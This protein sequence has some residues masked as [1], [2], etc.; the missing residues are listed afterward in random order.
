LSEERIVSGQP[1]FDRQERIAWWDQERLFNARV[2]VVGAGAL[3]NEVL[4]NLALLG[5]GHVLVIDFD[6]IED[7]NLSRTVLFR[8]SDA[9]DGASKALVAAERTLALNPNPNAVIK[10]MHGNVVWELGSGVYRHMD[11]V[12]G[13]L[14]NLEARLAV[15]LGCWRAGKTWIDGG[16]W[17]LSGSVTVYDSSAEKAC[18]ECGMTPEHYRQ[19]KVRYSCTNETV[20]TNIRQGR[21]PTTQTTSAVVAAIQS[22]EAIK[23]LHGLPSFPGRQL[24]F[25]GAPH[26][27]TNSDYEPVRMTELTLNP[28]CLCHG[29][30]R[31]EQ[32]V[33]LSKARARETTPRQL[34]E[35]VE[36]KPGVGDLTLDLGRTFVMEAICSRCERHIELN[37]PLYRVRDVDAV[38]PTCTITCPTCGF[39]SVGK[40]DC[41][42][43]GQQ[44]ISELR[45]ETFHVLSLGDPRIEPFLDYPLADLG[46]PPLHVLRICKSQGQCINAEL[47]GDLA[48]LW[49]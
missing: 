24:V 22:Q 10:A 12:L 29:E 4:K 23:V 28:A 33:E 49:D 18:Y 32:V 41:P 42:N 43:C 1:Y 8:A 17:E 39:V 7:S 13:C 3:G 36:V 26:F 9:A 45:L 35:M 47:T 21:E 27:Y 31:L 16:M 5:V 19:A 11:L 37:R 38:C 46:I 34:L 44:D 25:N 2:L 48:S 30:D 15:N 6:V 14:D 40:A 20:K